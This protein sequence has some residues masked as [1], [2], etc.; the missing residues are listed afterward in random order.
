MTM[1]GKKS[2]ANTGKGN[3]IMMQKIEARY[4]DAFQY[5][6]VGPL[7]CRAR[8]MWPSKPPYDS[9]A[10]IYIGPDGRSWLEAR[11][12]SSLDLPA[13]F[14]SGPIAAEVTLAGAAPLQLQLTPTIFDANI[15]VDDPSETKIG[16]RIS[17]T[18]IVFWPTSSEDS[19]GKQVRVELSLLN[20][21]HEAFVGSIKFTGFGYQWELSD[22]F[23]GRSES[24]N[25]IRNGLIDS[26]ATTLLTTTCG[27]DEVQKVVDD[28]WKISRL[29]SFALGTS[30]SGCVVKFS[31]GERSQLHSYY[32]W[33][34]FGTATN[35][36]EFSFFDTERTPG[37]LADFLS[38]ACANFNRIESSHLP[39]IVI[40][41]LEQARSNNVSDIRVALCVFAAE[42]FSYQIERANGVTEQQLSSRSIEQK[43]NRC[44]NHYGMAFIDRQFTGETRANV[45][46]P[47]MHTGQIPSMNVED[48]YKWS[49]EMYM[50]VSRMVFHQFGFTGEFIDIQNNWTVTRN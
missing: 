2:S 38:V 41:Y 25:S 44:K 17:Q 43:L 33:P 31:Q 3:L 23:N 32:E 1:Q 37:G 45:R 36:R 21:L 6:L 4:G 8:I 7:D 11:P 34:K 9:P 22:L 50:L 14:Q 5:G 24:A 16:F 49:Q 13:D 47:L 19:E 29:L 12:P 10:I 20:C 26:L 39:S 15:S 30:V 46:N 42:C 18:P 27:A 35:A 48:K 40:G 28:A